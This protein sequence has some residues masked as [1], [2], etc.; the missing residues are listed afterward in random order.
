MCKLSSTCK[1]S[2][3]G[4]WENEPLTTNQC[5]VWYVL[6]NQPMTG[7]RTDHQLNSESNKQTHEAI[8]SFIS[9]GF[10]NSG[11]SFSKTFRSQMTKASRGKSTKSSYANFPSHCKNHTFKSW[12]KP[13]TKLPMLS[14]QH[15]YYQSMGQIQNISTGKD[16]NN[17]K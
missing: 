11:P 15:S 13:L 14:V 1:K 3:F 6:T 17:S 7:F 12:K 2:T 5:H 8:H 9:L 4:S 10:R 16:K